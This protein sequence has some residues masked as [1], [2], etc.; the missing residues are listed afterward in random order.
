[1]QMQMQQQMQ[2]GGSVLLWVVT[3]PKEKPTR[4]RAVKRQASSVRRQASMAGKTKQVQDTRAIR[5]WGG[6]AVGAGAL[7]RLNIGRGS[8]SGPI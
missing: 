7:V 1:M 3:A 5:R 4:A 6:R 8:R 2:V